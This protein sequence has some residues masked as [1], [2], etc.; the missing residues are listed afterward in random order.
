MTWV[1]SDADTLG[2]LDQQ[3]L[4]GLDPP[5]NLQGMP[6]TPMRRRVKELRRPR[7]RKNVSQAPLARTP[8]PEPDC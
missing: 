5:L 3:V 7:A 1:E 2:R 4:G 6:Q 8:R